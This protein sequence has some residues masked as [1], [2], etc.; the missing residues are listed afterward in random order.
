MG[1][2]KP[3]KRKVAMVAWHKLL[4]PR[5]QGGLGLKKQ[6]DHSDSLLSKWTLNALDHP[7]SDWALVFKTNLV[8][9]SWS[10]YK[11]NRRTGYTVED[12]ILLGTPTS[13]G[14]QSYTKGLWKAWE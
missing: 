12:L 4:Q 9:F 5:T 10:N 1:F 6:L 7:L 14:R 3:G 11:S 8:A 13:Y 2:S